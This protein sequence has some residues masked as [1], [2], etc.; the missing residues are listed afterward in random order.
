MRFSPHWHLGLDIQPRLLCAVAAVLRRYGWQLQRYWRQVIPEGFIEGGRICQPQLLRGLLRELRCQLPRAC[1]VKIALSP[2][3]IMQQTI[4]APDAEIPKTLHY[5]ALLAAAEKRLLLARCEFACDFE[6]IAMTENYLM[7]AVRQQDLQSWNRLLTQAGLAPVCV[8]IMPC[9]LR[10]IARLS[11][12][13][14]QALLL[15]VTE[16]SLM[17]VAPYSQP[18]L[19]GV[20]KPPYQV[21]LLRQ[22]QQVSQQEGIQSQDMVLC[23][24]H[25]LSPPRWSPFAAFTHLTPPLPA[26]PTEFALAVGLALT[27]SG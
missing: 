2:E 21:D 17:W 10:R 26:H 5:S 11:Q 23:G 8:E 16:H 22:A 9:V 1:S 18:R 6:W 13:S 19:F 15:H 3:L 7:T 25:D 14:A 20:L 4:A 12:Q 27:E 24:S